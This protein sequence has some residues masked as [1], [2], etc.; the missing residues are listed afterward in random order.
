MTTCGRGRQLLGTAT[1][2]GSDCRVGPC[3]VTRK[4]VA[5]GSWTQTRLSPSKIFK[6]RDANADGWM[7]WLDDQAG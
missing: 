2:F 5:C 7:I 4:G 6:G 3:F 1:A